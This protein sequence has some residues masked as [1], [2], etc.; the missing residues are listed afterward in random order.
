MITLYHGTNDPD[1]I[2]LRMPKS[3]NTAG[4][5]LTPCK[6]I[7]S[8]YGQHI[9]EFE[10]PADSTINFLIRPLGDTGTSEWVVTTQKDFVE[11]LKYE[12]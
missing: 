7:A 1:S 5:Y 2:G 12:W 4:F 6:G 10:I 9:L 3:G 11:L 8:S